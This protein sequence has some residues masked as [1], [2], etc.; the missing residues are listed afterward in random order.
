M[1]AYY[2]LT[3]LLLEP[4]VTY[5]ATYLTMKHLIQGLRTVNDDL[6]LNEGPR[7]CR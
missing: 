1:E 7:Y 3:C 2:G 5:V 4:Y 6:D